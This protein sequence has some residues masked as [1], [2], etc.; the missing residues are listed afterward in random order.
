MGRIRAAYAT[1][2]GMS[3]V[4]LRL[5]AFEP[6]DGP[7]LETLRDMTA[8]LSHRDATHLIDRAI[9]AEISGSFIAHGISDNRFKRLDLSET[10]KVLGYAPQDDAFSTFPIPSA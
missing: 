5:G 1:Q 6:A 4:S 9:Q 10:C 2:R 7:P 8:W 3:C